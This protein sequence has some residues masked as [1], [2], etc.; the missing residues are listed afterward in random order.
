MILLKILTCGWAGGR[1]ET[2]RSRR[3]FFANSALARNVPFGSIADVAGVG[4]R[5][6]LHPHKRTRGKA[7]Q[8]RLSATRM[9][10]REGGCGA[11]NHLTELDSFGVRALISDGK[12]LMSALSQIADFLSGPCL[13][14]L[15]ARSGRPVIRVVSG[16]RR[17]YGS[18][19]EPTRSVGLRPALST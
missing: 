10:F 13:G 9:L 11:R 3:G 2:Q 7:C 15:C 14:P 17:K 16:A 6:P 18:S 1:F 12:S 19:G 5:R 4:Q 8:C